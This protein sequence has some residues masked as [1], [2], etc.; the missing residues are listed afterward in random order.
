MIYQII[1]SDTHGSENVKFEGEFDSYNQVEM[2]KTVSQI[3]SQFLRKKINGH[4]SIQEK[5]HGVV[6]CLA[7]ISVDFP[8]YE[9]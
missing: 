9:D 6:K 3:I 5:Q 7:T 1:R 4:V 2:R 8:I